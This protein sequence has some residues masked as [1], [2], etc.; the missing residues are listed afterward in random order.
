MPGK[1]L[2]RSF[3]VSDGRGKYIHWVLGRET[4]KMRR[5]K[6]SEIEAKIEA[7]GVD[8]GMEFMDTENV[9]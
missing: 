3:E 6:L 2:P 1:E 9:D 8:V 5:L 4:V 7:G